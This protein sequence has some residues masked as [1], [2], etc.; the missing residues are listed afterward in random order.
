MTK[1]NR[2][3]EVLEMMN[4]G[5]TLT[6]H[7]MVKTAAYLD[8]D[9]EK[10]VLITANVLNQLVKKNAIIGSKNGAIFTYRIA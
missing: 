5:W 10:T 4:N 3:A 6:R 8:K 7:V 2:Q 1:L 9:N